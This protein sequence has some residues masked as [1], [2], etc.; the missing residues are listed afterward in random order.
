MELSQSQGEAARPL[1]W[2]AE[3]LRYRAQQRLRVVKKEKASVLT[4]QLA[5]GAGLGGATC[6]T[7][8]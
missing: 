3:E 8:C 5:R 2:V 7:R 6:G 1:G 4:E